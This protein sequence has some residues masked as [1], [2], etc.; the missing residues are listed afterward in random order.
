MYRYTNQCATVHVI[1]LDDPV[2]RFSMVADLEKTLNIKIPMPLES[3]E[4]NKYLKETCARLGA[5]CQPP[6]TTA[7][8]WAQVDPSVDPRA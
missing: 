5:E 1:E 3:D 6:H 2:E 7:G 8:R 4:C